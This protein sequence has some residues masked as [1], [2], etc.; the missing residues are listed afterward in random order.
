MIALNELGLATQEP[1]SK[2]HTTRYLIPAFYIPATTIRW[3]R[4]TGQ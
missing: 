3:F 1:I 2:Y 4:A